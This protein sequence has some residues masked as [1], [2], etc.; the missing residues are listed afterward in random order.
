MSTTGNSDTAASSTCTLREIVLEQKERTRRSSKDEIAQFIQVSESNLASLDS[1][2]ATLVAR[3]E[4]ESFTVEALKYI[5]SPIHALPAEVLAEIFMAHVHN[6][7]IWGRV[8]TIKR[9][10]G[11]SQVCV[12]WRAV[13]HN[14][15]QLWDG[16]IEVLLWKRSDSA[17]AVYVDGWKEWLARSA[18]LPFSITLAAPVAYEPLPPQSRVLSEILQYSTRYKSLDILV[19]AAEPSGH[20]P[21]PFPYSQLARC[22]FDNLEALTV[23]F[24]DGDVGLRVGPAPRLRKLSLELNVQPHPEIVLPWAQLTDLTLNFRHFVSEMMDMVSE[25]FSRCSNLVTASLLLCP[26]PAYQERPI[27]TLPSLRQLS[28]QFDYAHESTYD[29]SYVTPVFDFLCLPSLEKLVLDF[30]EMQTDYICWDAARFSAFQLRSPNIFHLELPS[31]R[32]LTPEEF[33]IL[34]LHA[35]NLTRLEIKDPEEAWDVATC[36]AL[37]YTDGIPPLVPLLDTLVIRY[38]RIE[39]DDEEEKERVW[40]AFIQSRYWTDAQ[41]SCRAVPPAVS[42]WKYVEVACM[43]T[44]FTGDQI[45]YSQ[46]KDPD[47][48]MLE[49]LT[50]IQRSS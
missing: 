23:K 15:P 31:M 17:E 11:V 39:G 18:P 38:L 27:I 44:E 22:S 29:H 41:L 35:Q 9:V 50:K 37:T 2:I 5:A 49:L 12:D 33:R 43:A 4:R 14:T 42:R 46:R 32:F 30:E 28:I 6:V 1:Q 34:L 47:L 26:S 45:K 36:R 7:H 24:G 25:F 20:P 3:R 21:R 10:L 8:S 16:D 13:A 40:G 19:D 48:E